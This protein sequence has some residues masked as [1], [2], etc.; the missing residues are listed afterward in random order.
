MVTRSCSHE[1]YFISIVI[2]LF[3]TKIGN[4]ASI[5]LLWLESGRWGFCD[6]AYLRVSGARVWSPAVVER[7]QCRSRDVPGLYRVLP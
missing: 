5:F 3:M 1:W 7:L 2:G 4:I 6:L